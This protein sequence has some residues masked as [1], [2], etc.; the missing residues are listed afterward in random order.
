VPADWAVV[1]NENP[2]Q[3]ALDKEQ[4]ELEKSL[5]EIGNSFGTTLIEG[6]KYFVFPKSPRIST[7]LYAIVAGPYDYH[8][9]VTEGMPPMKIYAR[10]SLLKEVTDFN[11]MFTVT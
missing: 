3:E 4:A 11:E 2:D 10:K 5:T 1:S 6:G 8:E 9:R 7:Y